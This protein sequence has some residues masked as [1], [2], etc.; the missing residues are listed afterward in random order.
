MIILFLCTWTPLI[1]SIWSECLINYIHFLQGDILFLH[2]GK[3]P[4]RTG[5]IVVFNVD[6]SFRY[7]YIY[8]LHNILGCIVSLL[9]CRLMRLPSVFQHLLSFQLLWNEFL[10]LWHYNTIIQSIL[11]IKIFG[12]AILSTTVVKLVCLIILMAEVFRFGFYG[13]WGPM[14]L[15]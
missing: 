10:V 6:V 13:N 11:T 3:D 15:S 14:F 1:Y 5:E 12:F 9:L 2:M 8:C 4:I 7:I